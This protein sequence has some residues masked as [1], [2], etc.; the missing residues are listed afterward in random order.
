MVQVL[1]ATLVEYV[2]KPTSPQWAFTINS[3]GGYI[4]NGPGSVDFEISDVDQTE[5]ITKNTN[6]YWSYN[7]RSRN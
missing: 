7:K 2:K 3:V 6:V 5:L 1:K 4:Y